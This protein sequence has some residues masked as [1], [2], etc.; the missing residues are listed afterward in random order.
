MTTPSPSILCVHPN[1][2]GQF[3]RLLRALHE[4][5]GWTVVGM[6]C[7]PPD[8]GRTEFAKYYQYGIPAGRWDGLYPPM[9]KLTEDIRRGRSANRIFSKLRDSGFQPD[10]ILAHPG[11]GDA[12]FVRDYFPD[13]AYVA[14]LEYFYKAKSSDVDFDPE[15]P[16][17]ETDRQLVPLKNTPS[18][19]AYADADVQVTPTHWQSSLFPKSLRRSI[20]VLHDGIDTKRVAPGFD[21]F[22]LPDGRVLTTGDEVL[23]FVSRALEPYRGFHSFMRSLPE[24]QR[25]RPKL[26]TLVLGR[27]RVA[28]GRGPADFANWREFMLDELKGKVDFSRVFF[29]GLVPYFDYVKVLMVSKVHVYLTYPFVLSWSLL[30]A[31]ATGCAIV[32]SNTEPVREIIDDDVNG[33][34][35]DMFNY[36]NI[37]SAIERLME[38]DEIRE[39]MGRSARETA[40]NYDFDDVIFPKYLRLLQDAVSNAN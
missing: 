10:V 4:R 2:P 3:A 13:S 34:L 26:V 40:L 18:L 5:E 12:L 36:N 21:T 33:K 27:D 19:I 25:R 14:Y 1:F 6:G 22:Q 31:M 23:T 35:V 28:Y 37:G 39:K 30:E 9:S 15:F 32:C 11:W 24:L 38:G 17:S 20:Q 7:E 29:L 8:T 16:I